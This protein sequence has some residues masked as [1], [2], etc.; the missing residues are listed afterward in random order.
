[1]SKTNITINQYATW[2]IV[3]TYTD[4][5]GVPISLSGATAKFQ[6][7]DK[8][9]SLQLGITQSANGNGS[10]V[11]MSNG[12]SGEVTVLITDEDTATLTPGSYLYDL[13]ITKADG[14]AIRLIEGSAK[15]SAGVSR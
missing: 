4:S 11:N 13:L 14:V 9:D 1:M 5:D 3:I 8:A 6:I 2:S 10:L 15:V 12:A 7:R